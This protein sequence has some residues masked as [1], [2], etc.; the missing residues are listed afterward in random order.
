MT[1]QQRIGA[2]IA[3]GGAAVLGAVVACGSTRVT[4]P[5]SARGADV[6][7]PFK[8]YSS[9][10]QVSVDGDYVVL[11]AN[12]VPD[13]K[14]PYFPTSDPRYEAYDGPN[15]SF[16][17]APG[18]IVEETYTFRIPLHPTVSSTHAPTPLG[19]IGLAVNGVP[20]FNQYN[21]QNRPLTVE[22]DTFDQYDGHPTPNGEYHYHAEPFYLTS[23]NG[24]SALVGFLLDGFPVYGPV[25]NGRRV[26]NAD[27]D[28]LHGHT[29]PTADYP[30]GIYH[31]HITDADPYINGA[32]FAGAPGT[33]GR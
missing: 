19:P 17:L 27:L 30:G 5:A 26:T 9:A 10:V 31:Y 12:G 33:V 8:H 2:W 18:R 6:P 3:A 25:E 4:S 11:R 32:G 20:L 1:R 16:M 28:A 14:S 22:I 23:K 21:G 13:H 24:S 7:A 29:G 15:K